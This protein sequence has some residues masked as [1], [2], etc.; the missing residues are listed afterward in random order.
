MN[1]YI[2][3]ELAQ[4][5][6]GRPEQAAMLV[7]ASAAA[8][9]DA[10]KLQLIYA[11]ELATPDY[12]HYAL[13]RKLEM[14]DTAW[15][16]LKRL[17]DEK[18]IAL[19]LDVFGNRSL[20]L[21]VSIAARGIKVHSTDMSNP[22]LL[23]EIGRSS[24]DEVLLSVGGCSLAEIDQA[25]ELVGTRNK[26]ITLL[27]GFQGYPTESFANQ[28]SRLALLSRRYPATPRVRLGFAD[29]ADPSSMLCGMIPA[30]ALGA[31]ATVFEKHLT[32]AKSMKLEDHEAA[33]NPDEFSLFSA[34]LRECAMTLGTV[35]ESD[36]FLGMHESERAYRAKT[37]KHVVTTRGLKSGVA[38]VAADIALK[39]TPEKMAL[40]D[41][42]S[43]IGRR[44]ARDLAA[45]APITPAD[46]LP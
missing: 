7:A 38:L 42:R 19:Y 11:D 41:A 30:V 4:G 8:G 33:L 9:A 34:S 31:G 44:I 23:A 14:P 40:H 29:H 1:T 35:D 39:R 6:E 13:F 45:D 12:E 36:E 22:G 2:I 21:A 20:G 27:H 18:K 25:I 10:A 5:Y 17:A 16:D 43:V 24:I 28:I 46:I 15:I 37:R 32:L 26:S 3:A